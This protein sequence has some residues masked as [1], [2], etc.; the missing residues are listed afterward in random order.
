MCWNTT[1]KLNYHN[2]HVSVS[3]VR[4]SPPK[5][6]L[7]FFLERKKHSIRTTFHAIQ[8]MTTKLQNTRFHLQ[9]SSIRNRLLYCGI[10]LKRFYCIGKK[11]SSKS[12]TS[13][14]DFPISYATIL[15]SENQADLINGIFPLLLRGNWSILKIIYSWLQQR[16]SIDCLS[17]VNHS[18]N[19]VLCK[20][21]ESSKVPH[22]RKLVHNT[23]TGSVGGS[24]L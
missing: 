12:P 14:A 5:I 2:I 17:L 20:V 7:K 6:L 18:K 10:V 8:L 9:C 22:C 21:N 3:Q 23:N 1:S 11:L 16:K 4:V 24:S 19:T 13:F 15:T